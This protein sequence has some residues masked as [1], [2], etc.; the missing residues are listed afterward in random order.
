MGTELHG[1]GGYRVGD[2]DRN[3]TADLLKEAHAAGYLTLE[4]TDERLGT[5]LAARTRGEL[6]QLVADLPPESGGPVRNGASGQPGRHRASAPSSRRRLAWLVPLVMVITGV[7]LLAVLTRGFWFFPWPLLW[8]FFFAFGRRGRA[9]WRP[10][11]W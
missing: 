5:A 9:G 10:P 6:D 8:I 2:A 1:A 4:E 7:I 11:R 3:R